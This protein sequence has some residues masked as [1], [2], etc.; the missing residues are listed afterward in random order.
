MPPITLTLKAAR[1]NAGIGQKEA[2]NRLCINPS[3]LR[4]YEEGKTM[5]SYNMVKRME[6][7]YK[8]SADYIFFGKL[9]A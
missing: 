7:L 3:T 9:T 8:I 6:E 1:V 5:P 2:A 4:K